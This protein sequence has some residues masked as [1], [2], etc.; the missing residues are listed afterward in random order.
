MGPVFRVG[1]FMKKPS[2]IPAGRQSQMDSSCVYLVSSVYLIP[3]FHRY[4]LGFFCP[5]LYLVSRGPTSHFPL[6]LTSDG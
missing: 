6:P 1:G 3:G 4:L 2:T 5:A